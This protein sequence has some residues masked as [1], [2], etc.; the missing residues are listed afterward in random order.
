MI[1]ILFFLAAVA[2]LVVAVMALVQGDEA[3]ALRAAGIVLVCAVCAMVAD[4]R[5]GGMPDT[6]PASRP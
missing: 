4:R 1:R 6:P 5:V 2:F 3:V